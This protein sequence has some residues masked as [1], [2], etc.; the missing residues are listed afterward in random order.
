MWLIS[1]IQNGRATVHPCLLRKGIGPLP[2]FSRGRFAINRP[3]LG[4]VN[5]APIKMTDLGGCFM[6]VYDIGFKNGFTTLTL[7]QKFNRLSK[8]NIGKALKRLTAN[9]CPNDLSYCRKIGSSPVFLTA[10]FVTLSIK[11][12]AFYQRG[13]LI[14]YCADTVIMINTENPS[15]VALLLYGKK[16]VATEKLRQS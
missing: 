3:W 9:W 1:P 10:M 14:W 7:S 4:M 16:Y 12:H 5:I 8:T 15:L 13:A 2:D 6:N 11:Q